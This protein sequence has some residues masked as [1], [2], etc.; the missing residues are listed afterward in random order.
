MHLFYLGGN[1]KLMM[2]RVM[3]NKPKIVLLDEPLALRSIVIQD[4]QKYILK[5]QSMDVAYF[6][7]S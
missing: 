2:A 1:K 7:R 5:I 3:I 6:D 4:I